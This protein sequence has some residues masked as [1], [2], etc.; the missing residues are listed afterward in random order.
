MK[1]WTVTVPANTGTWLSQSVP[2]FCRYPICAARTRL[3]ER[4][5]ACD[6]RE[7]MA[8]LNRFSGQFQIKAQQLIGNERA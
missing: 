1:S 8:E 4:A 6:H 2:T 3:D 5:G 7:V